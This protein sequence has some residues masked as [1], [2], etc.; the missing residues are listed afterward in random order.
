VCFDSLRRPVHSIRANSATGMTAA[1]LLEQ[2][3]D[4]ENVEVSL[5]PALPSD[6][7]RVQSGLQTIIRAGLLQ[8]GKCSVQDEAT[9]LVVQMVG[10]QPG[11]R[12]LDACAAPGGKTMFMAGRLQGMV[13]CQQWLGCAEA[14]DCGM[15]CKP[16]KQGRSERRGLNGA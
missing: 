10:P 4:L 12:I 15:G 5:S 1:S 3:Q 11:D 6:F 13:S 2:L 8:E 16:G 7:V 14:L 9:G